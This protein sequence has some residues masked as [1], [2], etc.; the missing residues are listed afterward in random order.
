VAAR[1]GDTEW[2]DLVAAYKNLSVTLRGFVD[3][4]V[5]VHDPDLQFGAY[6]Q[7]DRERQEKLW[8]LPV[9]RHPLVRVD[10]RTGAR[11]L[12][13]NPLCLSHIEGL[14]PDENDALLELLYDQVRRD[15]HIV[16]WNWTVGDLALWENRT[17]LHRVVEDFGDQPRRN[18]RVV[19]GRER[20]VGPNGFTSTTTH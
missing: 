13:L 7:T 18:H 2:V 12:L 8:R 6:G 4:L 15:E 1:G 16:R 14:A 3:G 11:S 19:I 5:A 10:P 9:V 17:T 20:L